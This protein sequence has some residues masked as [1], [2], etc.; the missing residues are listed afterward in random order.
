M[1]NKLCYYLLMNYKK[2]KF[3]KNGDARGQLVALEQNG[4]IP[5]TIKRVYYI[6]NTLNNVVRGK[7]AH[8]KLK[9]ILICVSGSCKILLDDG[10]S[11]KNIILNKPYEGLYISNDIWREMYDFDDNT[12]LLVVAS[13]KYNENDYIRN[14]DDFIKYIKRK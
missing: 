8:K 12:V 4:N 13:E 7:H 10:T 1:I 2:I 6:Y 9:Q 3:R 5:F 14:Y 11:K